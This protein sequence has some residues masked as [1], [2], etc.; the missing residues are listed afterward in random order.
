MRYPNLT[1]GVVVFSSLA[2][3]ALA[4]TTERVSVG[5][6]GT[7][8]QL[9]SDHC[10][11]SRDGRFVA[12]E[13]ASPNLVTDDTN[14]TTDVFVRDR[15]TGE[16]IRASVANDGSQANGVSNHS[17]I[18]ADGRFVVF[19]SNATNLAS[20]RS[21]GLFI[22]DLVAQS[23]ER[24]FASDRI[25]GTYAPPDVSPDG[26]F[27]TFVALPATTSSHDIH[28]ID[29]TAGTDDVLPV[30]FT[31][32]VSPV[33]SANGRYV[34]FEDRQRPQL[35]RVVRWDRSTGAVIEIAG[36]E[37]SGPVM[38]EFG[39]DVAFTTR[40]SLDPSDGGQDA[41]AYVTSFSR[42]DYTLVSRATNGAPGNAWSTLD[43]MSLDGS[44]LA[45]SSNAT[46]LRA[47]RPQDPAEAAQ[48]EQVY[49]HDRVSG[50]T[51]RASV[52][53]SDV[54]GNAASYD[55]AISGDGRHIAFVSGA[56]NLVEGDTNRAEDVFVRT[57]ASVQVDRLGITLGS[58]AGGDVVRIDGSDLTSIG[59]CEVTFGGGAASV[60]S[61]A[62]DHVIVRTPPGVGAVDVRVSNRGGAFGLPAAFTYVSP[63]LAARYGNVGAA[64]GVRENVVAFGTP[65][66]DPVTRVTT[67]RT[68][69]PIRL[70]LL[71]PSSTENDRYV[72]YGWRA[73]PGAADL[74]STPIGSFVL[75]TPFIGGTPQPK[76]IWNTL[77][78][79]R[80]LGQPTRPSRRGYD[81]L[82][83]FSAGF[84][85]PTHLVF[86]G[87]VEDGLS[88]SAS[89]LSVTNAILVNVTP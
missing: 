81:V 54:S 22:R 26:R 88:T 15:L 30:G 71:E 14:R 3:A 48:Y 5:T 33:V 67:V 37:S 21:G 64:A 68:G 20:D 77:G 79:R 45:F 87:L 31:L 23:T 42:G 61:A 39:T 46:N 27:V 56:S 65:G 74:R 1:L 19:V 16:T 57:I 63:S 11:I 60:L 18:S 86:Q 32:G 52:S 47:P 58:E 9:G 80:V 75:A 10:S 69:Q 38:S 12:F 4:Q 25:L 34:A 40:N 6:G 8:A 43:S 28:L 17:K 29:R 24:L 35:G 51:I 2:F 41:D 7:Q 62:T 55:A 78:H 70:F 85:R 50:L 59:E 84:S 76:A 73:T 44:L 82:F 89:G 53:S 83:M 13:S 49:V 72:I 66:E 36:I